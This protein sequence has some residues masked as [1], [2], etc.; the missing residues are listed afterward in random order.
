MSD[1]A[2]APTDSIKRNR[3]GSRDDAQTKKAKI[4][5]KLAESLAAG[6]M[7]PF[8]DNCG[9]I[10]TPTWRKAW[11]KIHSGT[12]EHVRLSDD[13]GGI[14]AW[15]TLQTDEDGIVCLYRIF[16]K[17]LLATDQ[18]F[19]EVLLCNRKSQQPHFT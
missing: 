12:P 14:L 1:D 3:R 2:T 17:S 4:Q 8:C 11:V 13:E 16:K 5:S 19:R 6:E 18:D 10:E 9:A 15:Q 7:P